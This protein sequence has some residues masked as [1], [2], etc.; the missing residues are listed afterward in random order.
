MKLIKS[1]FEIIEQQAGLEGMYKGVEIVRVHDVLENK[2]A[3]LVADKLV[4]DKN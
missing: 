2:K 3:L 1:K 4:R